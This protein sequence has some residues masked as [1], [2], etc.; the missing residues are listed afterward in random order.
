MQYLEQIFLN[1]VQRNTLK[2]ILDR[3]KWNS[4]WCLS[5]LQ[6]EKKKNKEQKAENKMTLISP[7]I[8]IIELYVN[9]MTPTIKI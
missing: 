6:V 4:K 9:Y 7:D 3:L 5:Y 8:S 2:D 1:S